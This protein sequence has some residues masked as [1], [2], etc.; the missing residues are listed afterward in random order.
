MSAGPVMTSRSHDRD[1]MEG[2]SRIPSLALEP[3]ACTAEERTRRRRVFGLVFTTA[4]GRIL[5]KFGVK[6]G[7]VFLCC[8]LL[9][10][11]IITAFIKSDLRRQRAN[12]EAPHAPLVSGHTTDTVDVQYG[13]VAMRQ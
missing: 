4:Q 8:F 5:D 13:S 11:A 7:N 1:V 9:V 3:D 6:L 12:L 10:G 2:P